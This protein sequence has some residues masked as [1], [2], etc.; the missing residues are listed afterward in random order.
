[1]ARNRALISALAAV[2]LLFVVVFS[3][4]SGVIATDDTEYDSNVAEESY[5]DYN[6]ED[7]NDDGEELEEP[8]EG[9]DEDFDIVEYDED[10]EEDDEDLDEPL[11]GPDE[12]FDIVEMRHLWQGFFNACPQCRKRHIWHH[13]NTQTFAAQRPHT[14]GGHRHVVG[15]T[16]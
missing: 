2:L 13:L 10:D 5:E 4:A 1:M 16:N 12:D 3:P 6:K 7:G 15:F 9:A 8:L 14:H 11:E